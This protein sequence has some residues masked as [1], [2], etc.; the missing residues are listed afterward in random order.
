MKRQ[1]SLGKIRVLWNPETDTGAREEG[2]TGSDRSKM[3]DGKGGTT[4]ERNGDGER[5]EQKEKEGGAE[6]GV[7]G[8]VRQKIVK[9]IKKRV[10]IESSKGQ[11]RP[12]A[13]SVKHSRNPQP[14]RSPESVRSPMRLLQSR[15][16]WGD[17][18]H[19]CPATEGVRG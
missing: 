4:T 1:D 5:N 12:L 10:A 16:R 19:W 17:A 11:C 7:G 13:L 18:R 8:G 2:K 9:D 14:A 15:N 6:A 3:I